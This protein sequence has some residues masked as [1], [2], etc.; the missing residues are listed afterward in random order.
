MIRSAT[1]TLL[2]GLLVSGC[3]SPSTTNV[4]LDLPGGL[5]RV[6][7]GSDFYANR[8]MDWRYANGRIECIEGRSAKPMRTLHLLTHYLG[9]EAGELSMSVRTGALSPKD[10]AHSNTWS[11]FLLGAGGPDVDW[12]ISSLV[13]HWPA[14]DGGLIVGVDGQG[15]II[16]RSNTNADAPKGPRANIPVEAWPLIEPETSTG[17]LSAG[18]PVKLSVRANPSENNYEL[19]VT[20]SDPVT[21]EVL[22][23]SR[24]TELPHDYFEGNVAL[25]SHNSPLMEGEGYWFD[26]WTIGGSKFQYDDAR[27]FGPILAAQYTVSDRTLK[28]TAQMPP[29]GENDTPTVGLEL[30]LNG[31]WEH[32]ASATIIPGSYTAPLRVDDFEASTDVRY[33]LTYDLRTANGTERVHFPGTVRMAQIEDDEFV[34]ASLN[35]QNISR[36]RDLV[37]NHST[38]WYPHN[39]LTAAVAYHD[40]DLL[41]FAGDQIYEGGL[42]GIIRS[43]LDKTYLDYHYHWYRFLWA[44]R[45]LMRDRPTVTIPD[46][47]DVY[48]G[49]IWGHGGKKAEGPWRPQSDNGGY[50][51]DARF[52]NAVHETQVSHLPDP[53][54]PTPI[55]QDISVYYT[56][57]NYGD[58]SFAIVAD[59]MWKSAPR[60]VLPEAQVR[61]GWPENRDYDATSVTEA[62]L[63]GPRQ[64][65]FLN[66]WAHQFPDNVWMKVMLSQ[67]LFSN[68]ATLPSGS[69]DDRVVPQMRYAEPGEYISDDHKGTDMDSNGWPQSGRNRALAA[70]RKGFAFHVAGDQHLGSFVHYGIDEFG[71]GPNAFISPAIAN[72]WPR[73]W[74]PPEPGGNRKPG[75]PAYTGNHLDGFGNRMTVHAV[76][77]PVRSGRTP[78]A[79]YDRVPG[80]GIIRFNRDSRTITAEAW[81]RWVDPRSED[82]YQYSDWPVTVTQESNYG[83]QAAGYLP[84]INVE[85]MTEPVLTLIDETTMDTLYTLRLSTLPFRAKVFDTSSSY[86]AVVGDQSTHE[87]RLTGLQVHTM[88]SPET[89]VIT[90]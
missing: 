74:F 53:F 76:A 8:L 70:I 15:Q 14:E 82:A 88:E 65:K 17:N 90:F 38:I 26:D 56:N 25:V 75:A 31:D 40:P 42:A 48:H 37:W 51:M 68:L 50:I 59:R 64:L 23:E 22:A 18:D 45:D 41:F 67:T 46:D 79:L 62:H 35:C 20:A 69:F 39:E 80:Y 63:L 10:S 58:V 7:I 44:F 60:L 49:N 77:N 19:F 61:N 78:E 66:Q 84:P 55:E 81:P 47:H 71:D 5:E 12:R 86:T 30:M 36:G 24:Y 33:R 57:L 21:E 6:W 83:R 11:G 54:D 27:A 87:T 52:V 32:S 43:P 29:I 28:M 4:T 2:A 89:L 34:L 9:A 72:V 3:V 85:G 1:I 73:R 16:V 13:H